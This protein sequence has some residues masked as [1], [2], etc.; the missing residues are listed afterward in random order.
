M[1]FPQTITFFEMTQWIN[2]TFCPHLII[3]FI[4][5]WAPDSYP[6][7]IVCYWYQ[8]YWYTANVDKYDIASDTTDHHTGT[9]NNHDDDD[10]EHKISFIVK[11]FSLSGSSFWNGPWNDFVWLNCNNFV[12]WWKIYKTICSRNIC[13]KLNKIISMKYV[14]VFIIFYSLLF[15]TTINRYSLSGTTINWHFLVLTLMK[16]TSLL[17]SI[18]LN[19]TTACDT[20]LP[21]MVLYWLVVLGSRVDLMQAPS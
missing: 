13:H 10:D 5:A 3:I 2:I 11:N 4:W 8:R 17:G 19:M 21:R 12:H 9:D 7:S 6:M 18:S 14:F 20:R 1:T 16:V 15:C